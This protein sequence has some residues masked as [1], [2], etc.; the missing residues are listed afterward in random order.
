MH[1]EAEIVKAEASN[2]HMLFPLFITT[3]FLIKPS[4]N[5]TA[6]LCIQNQVLDEMA[7]P[8]SD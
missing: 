6:L 1:N 3:Y 7:E 2:L 8:A 5:S 4:N